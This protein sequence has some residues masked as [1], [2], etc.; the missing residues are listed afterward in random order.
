MT[1]ATIVVANTTPLA[2][3][4][5]LRKWNVPG[6]TVWAGYGYGCDYPTEEVTII[7]TSLPDRDFALV[8]GERLAAEFSEECVYVEVD[9]EAWFAYSVGK[10]SKL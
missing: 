1:L 7:R 5:V 8:I 3:V 6:G 10:P 9:G 2:V 4:K